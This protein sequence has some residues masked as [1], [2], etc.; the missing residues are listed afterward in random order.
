MALPGFYDG[1]EELP[2]EI[3]E[4]WD[5]LDFDA[6][7]FLGGVGLTTPAGERGRTPL[8]QLWSRPSCDI[9]GIA[10]GYAGEGKRP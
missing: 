5:G 10:G 8:E 4:L 2:K 3:L 7:A 1:V 9:N 6:A